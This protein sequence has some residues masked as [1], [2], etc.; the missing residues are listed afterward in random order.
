MPQNKLLERAQTFNHLEV[1][2]M[3]NIADEW[4]Q[5][6]ERMAERGAHDVLSLPIYNQ[7]TGS[8]TKITPREAQLLREI[9]GKDFEKFGYPAPYWKD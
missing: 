4:E 2:R 7:T 6:R 1:Y 8:A 9:Y 5:L 3:E